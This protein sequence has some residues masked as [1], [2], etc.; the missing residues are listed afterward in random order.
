M[1][2]FSSDSS[3]KPKFGSTETDHFILGGHLQMLLG[4]T[5]L[6]KALAYS[7]YQISSNKMMNF[8]LFGKLKGKSNQYLF[9]TVYLRTKMG[10]TQ[11]TIK[12]M[13]IPIAAILAARNGQ[14]QWAAELI[15][16]AFA[17]PNEWVGWLDKWMLLI[18][19]HQQLE[20]QLGTEAF[21]AA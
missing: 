4:D 20:V 10:D 8:L 9:P 12:Q 1:G 7:S 21:R 17:G 13:G 2:T 18:E 19:T 5:K 14:P 16:L 15:G 11:I 3:L 6:E